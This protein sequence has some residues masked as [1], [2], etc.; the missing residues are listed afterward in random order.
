MPSRRCDSQH[1]TVQLPRALAHAC[2][3]PCA[4]RM[5]VCSGSVMFCINHS[6]HQSRSVS[7]VVRNNCAL[8]RAAPPLQADG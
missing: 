1:P 7:I 3:S 5:L 2:A 4:A 6:L 8:Y